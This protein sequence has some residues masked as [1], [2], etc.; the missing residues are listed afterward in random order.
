MNLA[1]NEPAFTDKHKSP[2]RAVIDK[3][4]R[5]GAGY[6]YGEPPSSLN[7]TDTEVDANLGVVRLGITKTTWGGLYMTN[8]KEFYLS[9]SEA[10]ELIRDLQKAV[11]TA[12]FTHEQRTGKA[13]AV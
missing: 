10:K 1:T 13:I 3:D 8:Y 12:T 4:G 6:A 7:L 5:L 2:I 9:V 11:D